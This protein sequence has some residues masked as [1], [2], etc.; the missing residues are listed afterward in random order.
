MLMRA[1]KETFTRVFGPQVALLA[2]RGLLPGTSSAGGTRLQP[3]E[4]AELG[5]QGRKPLAVEIPRT[6][7]PRRGRHGTCQEECRPSRAWGSALSGFQGL[8]PL[9]TECRP[10]RGLRK[11]LRCFGVPPRK[12]DRNRCVE[13]DWDIPD[14]ERE[15]SPGRSPRR[16][17]SGMSP[18]STRLSY[19]L[20]DVLH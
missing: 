15:T 6:L 18:F 19:A 12:I 14:F 2:G 7:S 9:A 8:T 13:Q 20:L 1:K 4:G 16:P 5:S 3:P 17:K 11:D 10:F